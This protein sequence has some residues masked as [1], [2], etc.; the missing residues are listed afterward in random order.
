MSIP[1]AESDIEE[2]ALGWLAELGYA[3][4]SGQEIAPDS[5][6]AERTSYG[7]VTLSARMRAA[8][9]RLNPAVPIEARADALRRIEQAEYPGLIEE[10]RRLHGFFVEGVP[11]EF[12]GEDG[13]ESRSCTHDRLGRSRR[14]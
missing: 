11:V 2:A 12:Y 1:F 14:Q 10:N 8:V 7:D 9:D 4:R 13:V 5:K 6:G 3:I